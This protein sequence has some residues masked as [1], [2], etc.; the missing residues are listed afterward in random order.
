MSPIQRDLKATIPVPRNV[1]VELK[2]L[3]LLEGEFKWTSNPLQPQLLAESQ[4]MP[5]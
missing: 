3:S 2:K 4:H 5:A 1:S